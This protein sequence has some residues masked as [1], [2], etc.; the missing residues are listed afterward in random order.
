ME[1]YVGNDSGDRVV[2]VGN[3]LAADGVCCCDCWNQSWSCAKRGLK[4]GGQISLANS[5]Y[6][7]KIRGARHEHICV[8]YRPS[9]EL[10]PPRVGMWEILPLNLRA[11]GFW[12]KVTLSA[13]GLKISE[14]TSMILFTSVAFAARTQVKL[15]PC[16]PGQLSEAVRLF[17]AGTLEVGGAAR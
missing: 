6:A 15:L 17:Q 10:D 1:S 9:C 8:T 2:S 5:E 16:V 13:I 7:T 11:A 12:N 3:A 4:E 14:L